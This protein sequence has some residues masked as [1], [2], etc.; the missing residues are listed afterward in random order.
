MGLRTLPAA[1]TALVL[2]ALTASGATATVAKAAPA[3][4]DPGPGPQF[5]VVNGDGAPAGQLGFVVAVLNAN[6]LAKRGAFDAQFCGGTLTTPTTVVTA[7]HCVVDPVTEAIAEPSAL[8]IGFGRSLRPGRLEVAAISRVLVHPS[9]DRTSGA[10]DVAVIVLAQPNLLLPTLTPLQPQEREQYEAA[11]LPAQ[12]AGWGSTSTPD[13][14]FPTELHAASVSIFP[15]ASCGS[16]GSFAVGTVAFDGFPRGQADPEVML[17]AAG[18]TGSGRVVDSCQ[19]DSGGP[20]I[21]GEGL[22]ARLVGIVSWGRECASTVPG[23]YTRV[24]SVWDFLLASDAVVTQPPSQAPIVTATG[25]QEAIEV[26]FDQARDGRTS[27]FAATATDPGTGIARACYARPRRDGLPARCVIEG[28][29]DG[30]DYLVA[31]IAANSAGNSPPSP[32]LVVAPAAL[33][34]RAARA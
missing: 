32:G 17:C 23:V 25:L 8:R 14:R 4:P 3:G 9:F 29:Q 24:A 6:L 7:A 12:I 34:A 20:L 28:L 5:R 11:G 26:R 15:P 1:A 33:P 22:A 30:V 16:G 27:V 18:A 31:G 10:R 19:G 2:A 13:T 21:V